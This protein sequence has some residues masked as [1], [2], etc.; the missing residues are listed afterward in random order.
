VNPEDGFGSARGVRRVGGAAALGTAFTRVSPPPD[1]GLFSRR[2]GR[3]TRDGNAKLVVGHDM[4]PGAIEQYRKLAAS[5]HHAQTQ[6]GIKIV[7]MAST[8]AGEG[9]TLTATNLALTLSESYRRRVALIDADLRRPTI[10]DVFNLPNV[11]GLNDV[12]KRNSEASCEIFEVSPHL[13]VLTAG[14]PNP[15]PI[16]GLTSDR[17]RRLVAAAAEEYDW[18]VIDTPPVGLLP[19]ANLLA[20]MVHVVLLVIAAG[21][22]PYRLVTR[23]VEALGRDRIFGV[24]LNRVAAD[25]W[26]G[27]GSYYYEAYGP[28]GDD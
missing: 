14:R 12:L 20:S 1:T 5:L 27:Y 4:R 22:T 3:R 28:D 26:D 9:K 15:D 10:H 2:G 23:S 25:N 19:D 18:V 13:S 24:V 8:L 21:R 6:Q 16:S 11:S 17:M 7:M